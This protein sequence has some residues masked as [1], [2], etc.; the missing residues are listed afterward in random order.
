MVT[1]LKI[2]L[3]VTILDYASDCFLDAAAAGIW[4]CVGVGTSY[5]SAQIRL[6]LSRLH[7]LWYHGCICLILDV[8]YLV[9]L[10]GVC[11]F[12]QGRLRKNYLLTTRGSN[13]TVQRSLIY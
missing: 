10:N 8:H 3:S 9:C 12:D 11:Y 5:N 13:K 6:K 1:R 7:E 4:V 2:V